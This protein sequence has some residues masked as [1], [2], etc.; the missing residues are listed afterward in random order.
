MKNTIPFFVIICL[1]LW[2]SACH[3]ESGKQTSD[4]VSVIF[5]TDMG[6]DYDDAGALTLLHALA[7]SGEVK[8]LATVSCNLDT[9]ATPCIDVINTYFG[10]PEIPIGAPK[11]SGV[12]I[13]DHW[14]AEKWTEALVSNYP[15]T[16]KTTVDA[17]DA[18]SIYR[19]ILASE[20]DSSVVVVTV[21]FLTNLAGLLS[22]APDEYSPLD[23][24]QL[25]SKKVKRLVSMAGGFPSGREWN[26]FC[27]SVASKLAFEEWP[28][29]I[30][31]SGFE[32]GNKILTG[33]RLVASDIDETPAKTVFT[34]CLRQADFDGRMSWD[35]ATALVAVRG[36]DRYFNTTKGRIIVNPDGSNSWENTPDGQHEYLTWK[37]PA[38]E[39]AQVIE[40]LMMHEKVKK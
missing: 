39:L 13:G 26:V 29:P 14:H 8:I 19:R 40:D 37:M 17:P 4:P 27:D 38:D 5:D 24:K 12:N 6:P 11:S 15:H 1:L 35:E 31:F 30:L 32:I 22:S 9:L 16:L 2:L 20:A 34:I 28:T 23:G 7:D 25:V 21:G 33:K 3:S 10:R 36:A 18:V